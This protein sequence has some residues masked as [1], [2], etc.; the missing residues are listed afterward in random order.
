MPYFHDNKNLFQC[1]QINKTKKKSK[2]KPFP[3]LKSETS[4]EPHMS[5]V[6]SLYLVFYISREG[7]WE[8]HPF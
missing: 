8:F 6:N 4:V 2:L 7:G 1:E 5:H 3:L